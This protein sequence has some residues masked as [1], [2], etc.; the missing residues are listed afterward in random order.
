MA[1]GVSS[2]F[3]ACVVLRP[4][5]TAKSFTQRETDGIRVTARGRDGMGIHATDAS[6]V[7][8]FIVHAVAE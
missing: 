4:R 1:W 7:H 6:G 3:R 8:R 5:V 2:G